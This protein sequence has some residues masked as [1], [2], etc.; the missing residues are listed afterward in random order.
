MHWDQPILRWVRITWI[1]FQMAS[2]VLPLVATLALDVGGLVSEL[3]GG[4]VGTGV[5]LQS[6]RQS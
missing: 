6:R 1:P 2:S 3:V 5:E 4:S